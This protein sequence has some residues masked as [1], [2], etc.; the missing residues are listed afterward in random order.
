MNETKQLPAPVQGMAALTMQ[1]AE[2]TQMRLRYQLAQMMPRNIETIQI[3]VKAAC[4]N[5]SLA[6]KSM[7]CFRRG[8]TLILGPSVK[9]IEELW[10]L[11]GNND[12][13]WQMLSRR[14]GHTTEILVYAV[15][16]QKNTREPLVLLVE[17][18]KFPARTAS[19]DDIYYNCANYASRRKRALM[20]RILPT[21]LIDGAV[22]LCTETL[23]NAY[24]DWQSRLG[25]MVDV[26]KDQFGVTKEQIEAFLQCKVE[27]ANIY[28]YVRMRAVY[29]S[30]NDHASRPADW[31]RGAPNIV[32]KT[33]QQKAAGKKAGKQTQKPADPPPNVDAESV[34]AV[35]KPADK[36]A[37]KPEEKPASKTATTSKEQPPPVVQEENWSTRLD[38]KEATMKVEPYEGFA[39]DAEDVLG[40][41]VEEYTEEADDEP[42]FAE[43]E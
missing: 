38:K 16:I 37:D 40:G 8:G 1:T 34:K 18:P 39:Q 23:V 3:E 42:S 21:S 5:V 41:D 13:G 17:D 11:Y 15:D 20:E 28:Q 4:Q 31:F 33:E 10:H 6:E 43:F 25:K 24:K 36:P 19:Q 27:S 7:Y 30:L 2:D 35:E 29:N 12:A 22:E 14:E 9:L 32:P 26:F